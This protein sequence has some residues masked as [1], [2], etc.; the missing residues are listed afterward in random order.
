MEKPKNK[1][2]KISEET[3]DITIQTEEEINNIIN[4]FNNYLISLNEDKINLLE[5]SN[6]FCE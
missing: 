5:I 4:I 3:K 1:E 6:F 2:I